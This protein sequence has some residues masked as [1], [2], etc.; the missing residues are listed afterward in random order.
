MP[1]ELNIPVDT[2][3]PPVAKVPAVRVRVLLVPSVKGLG[4]TLS[5]RETV[6]P[7]TFIVMLPSMGNCVIFELASLNVKVVVAKKVMLS[8]EKFFT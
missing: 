7:G 1:L 8:P 4:K 5:A 2:G 3:L 6:P